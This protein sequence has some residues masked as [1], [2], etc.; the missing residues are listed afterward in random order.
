MSKKYLLEI[1]VE[2][3]PARYVGDAL[4]QLKTNTINLLKEER[5]NFDTINVYSTPRRLTLIIDGL[6]DK[7]EEVKEI[8]KG[9]SKKIAFEEE[10]NPSKALSGFMR[11]QGVDLGAIY[12]EEFNGEDYVYANVIKKGKPIEEILAKNLASLIKSI[13]FPK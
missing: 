13:T 4:V 5:I 11:G 10:G 3:I 7:Q 6:V 9:P 8:V 1:G 12:V 2:E